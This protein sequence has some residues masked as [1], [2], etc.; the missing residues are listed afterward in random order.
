M[1]KITRS[2]RPGI[3][4]CVQ[5][6]K[7]KCKYLFSKV[8]VLRPKWYILV[9]SKMTQSVCVCSAHQNVVLLVDAV[10][11]TWH[12]KTW[13]CCY[14]YF[15]FKFNCDHLYITIIHKSTGTSMVHL[16]CKCPCKYDEII[17]LTFPQWSQCLMLLLLI[18]GGFKAG[19]V[20]TQKYF[21]YS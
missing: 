3:I 19:D 14:K 17:V 21:N 7:P 20:H 11:G 9:G 16:M 5:R 6:K 12:K 10:D 15:Q 4:Y 8:G 2:E 13:L 1:R 18:C